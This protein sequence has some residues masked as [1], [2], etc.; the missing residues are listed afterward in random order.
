MNILI[1]SSEVAG[2]LA[3]VCGAL[4]TALAALGH[5]VAVVTP[6]YRQVS[7]NGRTLEPTGVTF[8]VPIG[9]K[10]VS[11]QFL[12]SRLPGSDVPVFFVDQPEYFDRNEL[13]GERGQDY[14]DNCERFVFFS[15]AVMEL[16]RLMEL[17]VGVLHCNDW[18]PVWCQPICGSNSNSRGV[19]RTSSV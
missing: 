16:I 7:Q 2:G 12:S 9:S 19:M 18:Q 6:A 15:R 1:I 17:P 8:D 10:V 4:P 5:D 14:K 3:D 13:Y 11:G